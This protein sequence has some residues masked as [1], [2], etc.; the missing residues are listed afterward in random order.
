M[1]TA[2]VLASMLLAVGAVSVDLAD[3][4]APNWAAGRVEALG[5]LA[6]HWRGPADE[7]EWEAIYSGPEGGLILGLDKQIVDGE[8]VLFEFERIAEVDGK[9]VLAPAPRGRPSPVVFELTEHDRE[10]RRAVFENPSHDFPQVITYH[11]VA[12]DRLIVRVEASREGE[13]VGFELDLRLR[14]EIR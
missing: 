3:E 7:G 6:G 14:G 4:P 10:G 1:A 9:V 5:W 11:R 2:R 12:D 13:R 8:V